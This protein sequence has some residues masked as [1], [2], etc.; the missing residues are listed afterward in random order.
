MCHVLV[1]MQKMT[2]IEKM[3]VVEVDEMTKQFQ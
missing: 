1:T 3:I 2:P